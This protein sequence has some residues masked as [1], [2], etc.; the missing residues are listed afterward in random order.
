MKINP[1]NIDQLFQQA[2][3]QNQLEP[4]AEMMQRVLDQ[5]QQMGGGSASE[6]GQNAPDVQAAAKGA[7][8][9]VTGL[10]NGKFVGGLSL[11]KAFVAA[12]VVAGVS[13]AVWMGVKS[14]NV[15]TPLRQN[16]VAV[17]EQGNGADA[18]AAELPIVQQENQEFV[19]N[20]MNDAGNTAVA[21]SPEKID[22][23]GDFVH[24]GNHSQGKLND[25]LEV[26]VGGSGKS[27]AEMGA[28]E[29]NSSGDKVSGSDAGVKVNAKLATAS[30]I[31]ASKPLELEIS[32]TDKT[33]TVRLEKRWEDSGEVRIDWGLG[34]GFTAQ[35]SK[36]IFVQRS[37]KLR[38]MVQIMRNGKVVKSGEEMLV[39]EPH[40]DAAEILV[41]EIITRNGDGLNDEFYVGM[42][43]PEYFE[44]M[45]MDKVNRVVFRSNDS[46]ARWNGLKNGMKVEA[47]EYAVMVAYRYSNQ[48][49]LNYVRQILI[50]QD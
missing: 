30:K 9:K 41:P 13:V 35:R 1:E 17:T 44:V 15:V 5:W 21:A 47:G 7:G 32:A 49:K 14:E 2:A 8:S 16:G 38:V 40:G 11:G 25:K 3:Q 31:A 43:Q 29:L 26:N 46:E 4:P 34:Q 22:V 37:A 39:V 50:V 48:K 42:P 6:A 28:V 27:V 24:S 20:G 36:E 33:Y 19:D 12:M 45:V 18:G 10:A 23:Q